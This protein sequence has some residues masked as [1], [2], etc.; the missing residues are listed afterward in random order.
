[1]STPRISA[2][3]LAQAVS[4]LI[5]TLAGAAGAA[6][7]DLAT[8]ATTSAL[9]AAAPQNLCGSDDSHA[10]ADAPQ[11]LCSSGIASA[12]SGNGPWAWTC[13]DGQRETHCSANAAAQ[14]TFRTL[15]YPGTSWT[16]FWGINDFG[17]IGGEYRVD[18]SPIHAMTYHRGRFDSLDPNG[19]FGD[20]GSASGGPNDLGALFGF[21]TDEAKHQHGYL[22]QWG[23]VETVDFPGHLNSNVDDVNIFGAIAGV[24][25][26]ADGIQHGVLRRYGHDTAI[27]YPGSL[28]TY[29]LGID[30]S[31]G[32]VGMWYTDPR[33][34]HG[35]YRNPNGRY[36]AIDVPIAGPGGT[37]T[38]GINDADQIVGY[39]MDAAHHYHGFI[40]TRGK[41]DYLDVPDAV[42]TFPT[43]INNFGVIVGYY[44]DSANHNHGFVAT[45]W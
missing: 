3:R 39:Y 1:M 40:Q 38:I 30:N 21:Y 31:G 37:V 27:D 13:N 22:L 25:W 8:D 41:I 19:L 20:R 35:F 23:H 2:H 11:N 44:I 29:P 18:G 24:Y 32:I 14:Y 42:Q 26:D 36:S 4:L 6:V 45:P 5:V 15:D 9:E 43:H 34:T 7:P 10:L 16:K 28:G 12:L 17:D 33:T